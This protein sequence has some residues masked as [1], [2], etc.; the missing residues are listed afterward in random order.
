MPDMGLNTL[1][2][3]SMY[4]CIVFVGLLICLI[5]LLIKG[6]VLLRPPILMILIIIPDAVALRKRNL[7]LPLGSKR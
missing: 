3:L 7:Y 6:L 1:H 2:S 5:D 4:Y